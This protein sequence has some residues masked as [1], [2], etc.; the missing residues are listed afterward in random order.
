MSTKYLDRRCGN[1]YRGSHLIVFFSSC[2]Q[3]GGRDC[4]DRDHVG[5][6]QQYHP[7]LVLITSPHTYNCVQPQRHFNL[8]TAS[9]RFPNPWS[10]NGYKP[11]PIQL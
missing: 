5:R 3:R 8:Q 4:S 2:G 11:R 6:D 9:P 7:Q 10:F 1:S